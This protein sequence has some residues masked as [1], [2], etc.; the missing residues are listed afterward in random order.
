MPN[1]TLLILLFVIL[2]LS[3]APGV[4]AFGAGNIPAYSY[5]EEKAFRHGDIEDV[6]GTLAKAVG[7]GIFGRSVKFSPLDVKRVYFGNWLRD[8]KQ[9]SRRKLPRNR[10]G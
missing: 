5:L 2:A 10:R 8:C 9:S 4:S 3:C 1:P 7:G 6:I